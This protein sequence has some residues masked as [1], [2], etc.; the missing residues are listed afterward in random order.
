MLE[1]LRRAEA[2]G[3]EIVQVGTGSA[4]PANALY[5]SLPFTETYRGRFWARTAPR[6]S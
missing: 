6:S 2:L 3:A 5:D 4:D 1:G